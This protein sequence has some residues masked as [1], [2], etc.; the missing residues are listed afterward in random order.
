[1]TDTKQQIID[2]LLSFGF[3]LGGSRRMA[4]KY[5]EKIAVKETT[6]WDIYC[7]NGDRYIEKLKQL[8]FGEVPV[9]TRTYF[10]DLLVGIWKNSNIENVEVLVRR[11]AE[12]YT[13]AFEQISADMYYNFLWKSSPARDQ[14]EIDP[15][16]KNRVRN[17]FNALFA[18][19]GSKQ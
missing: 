15:V 17:F 6:D 10:D 11:D 8:G 14:N 16:F 1:M 5:P 9:Y 12:K 4:E 2:E 3:R 19:V 18:L 7:P 13:L